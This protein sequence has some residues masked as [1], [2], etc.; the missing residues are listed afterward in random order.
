MENLLSESRM[1]VPQKLKT[2]NIKPN[3]NSKMG[4]GGESG[5]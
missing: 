2:N 3:Y 1:V 4:K 5:G